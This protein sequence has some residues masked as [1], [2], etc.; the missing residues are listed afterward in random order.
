V[1]AALNADPRGCFL[2]VSMLDSVLATMGWVVS[3]HLIA[4]ETP[5]ANG[6]ENPTSAPSGTFAAAG[7]PINIAANRD[8]QWRAL[9]RH[10][11]RGDLLADPR[12]AA[13]EDRKRNRHALRASLEDTLRTRP[14]EQW[15]D[16]L[17]ALGVPAGP[18]LSVQDA[19]ASPQIAGR[20]FLERFDAVPG[21]ER[22]I[23]VAG[24]G[25]R[26]DGAALRVGAPPPELG[27]DNDAIWSELGLGADE[28]AELRAE[29]VI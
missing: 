16:E 2:D 11:G 21:V 15:A 27:Q 12:Y 28:I 7:G 14:A 1:A 23:S 9:C 8:E 3:N 18:V 26:Q 13:R 19:L 17:N 22:P 29:G 24:S 4:G 25:V 6:N 10:L 20:E 5:K